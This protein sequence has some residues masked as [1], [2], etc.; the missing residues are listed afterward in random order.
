MVLGLLDRRSPGAANALMAQAQNSATLDREEVARFAKD[1]GQ[2]WDANGPFKPLHRITAGALTAIKPKGK[3]SR[4][5]QFW[6]L[7]AAAGW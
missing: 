4:G 5:Y 3:P 1:A 6:I 2:W 7:A